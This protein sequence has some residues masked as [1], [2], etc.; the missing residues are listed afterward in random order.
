MIDQARVFR[1]GAAGR[2]PCVSFG[3]PETHKNLLR[4]APGDLLP[5]GGKHDSVYAYVKGPRSMVAKVEEWL[6][7]HHGLVVCRDLLAVSMAVD[8]DRRGGAPQ[9]PPTRLGELR[10]AAK[11]YEGAGTRDA[12]SATTSLAA[13]LAAVVQRVEAYQTATSWWRCPRMSPTR[14]I[15]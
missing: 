10:R 15:T 7:R 14:H 2:D 12:R 9:E 3:F 1:P 13:E 11:V 4:T 5:A 6:G 8:F